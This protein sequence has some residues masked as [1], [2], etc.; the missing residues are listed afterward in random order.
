MN[1]TLEVGRGPRTTVCEH[2]GGVYSTSVGF[3]Y[4]DGGPFAI[5]YATLFGGDHEQ[6]VDLAIGIGTWDKHAEATVSAFMSIWPTV[7]ELRMGFEDPA[8]SGWSR[9]EL[10]THQ[11]TGDQARRHARRGEF[12]AIAELVLGGDPAVSS[13]LA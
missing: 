10:L 7:H 2:C 1:L 12:L 11:L 9:T 8:T 4:L 5:Y 3:I 6:R 13:H